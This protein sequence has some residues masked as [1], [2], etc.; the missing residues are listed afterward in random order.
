MFSFIEIRGG[1]RF[2][3]IMEYQS[4]YYVGD[5][6]LSFDERDV[7][8]FNRTSPFDEDSDNDGMCDGWEAWFGDRVLDPTTEEPRWEVLDPTFGGDDYQDPDKDTIETRWNFVHWLWLDEDGD[9]VHEPPRGATPYDPVT[10]G[11]NIHEYLV[12]TNPRKADTDD[13]SYP[14]GGNGMNDFDENVFHLTDP[15]RAYTDGD[16]VA[17]GFEVWYNM[18]PMDTFDGGADPDADGLTNVQEF[19]HDTHPFSSDTDEDLMPDGWEIQ[20]SLDPHD[21]MDAMRDEDKEGLLNCFEYFNGTNPWIIDTDGDYLTD[22]EEARGNWTVVVDGA[23]RL[24]S[25]DPLKVDSDGDD[26]IDDEDG[27][28]NNDPLEEILDGF[29][30]D[31]DAEIL[32]NNGIDDDGDGVIDDGRTGIPAVGLP[33]G[34]DEEHDFNDY[35]EVFVYK[36]NASNPDSDGDGLDDW[37]EWFTDRDTSTSSIERTQPLL[38]DTDSDG[39]DDLTEVMGIR[40]WLPDHTNKVRRRTDPLSHDSDSDGLSDGDEVL[41][42][43]ILKTPWTVNSTDP[44]NEDT[45]GDGMSDHYEVMYSD[46]DGD[47]LPTW[48]EDLYAGVW[49]N[50]GVKRDANLE[51]HLDITEDW[52]SD[53]LSNLEEFM[54]RTDPWEEDTD[55]DG[56]GD[57]LD[58]SLTPDHLRPV[59]RVPLFSD[60]DGDIMPDWWEVINGLDPEDPG[61]GGKDPDHDMLVNRDEY[62]YD[63]DPFNY[64]TDGDGSSDLF[65][66][67]LMSSPDAWDT[68]HDGMADWW[69]RLYPEILDHTDPSDADSND[70]GD[71]WTNYQE[72]VYASDPYNHVPTN[73][74]LTST[75]GDQYMD[76]EDPYP[77]LINT[78]LRPLNPTRGSGPIHPL[79]VLTPNGEYQ[80]SADMDRDGLNNSGESSVP[81]GATDPTDPDT[82]GDG[83]PDGWEVENAAWDP[84]TAQPNL[85]PLK[86]D[87]AFLDPDWDGVSYTLDRDDNGDWIIRQMDI[88]GDG[89]FDP[90]FENETLCNLEEY[91]FGEDLDR[92]GINERTPDPNMLDT[93]DDEIPDGWEILLNDADGDN[94]STWFE[95]TYA[96]DPLSPRGDDGADGD[97]D[98]DG[99]SNLDEFLY[100]TNPIDPDD[101]P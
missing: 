74:T 19:K 31:G 66:H 68:D 98:G 63:L 97:P 84:L 23:T 51:G 30:N 58:L 41:V 8:M 26:L 93:D 52:D 45:D 89:F 86:G 75:D 39:L 16:G 99:F 60:R 28:G 4:M 47:G 1:E 81:T 10:V 88:N 95:L 83:M 57:L 61:D 56:I 55:G 91:L 65:D 82:D 12:G 6:S 21:P 69:E 80:A 76:D 100:N 90:T 40:I 77:L 15:L 50:V 71:R 38:S 48:W 92:D 5:P 7:M 78:T 11:F 18:D 20:Q 53:G 35:N 37:L 62:I 94:L 59:K 3:N 2:T 72:W 22:F 49:S 32:Q 36:T 33:E 64:N 79:T 96:L 25:S 85:D 13:D 27:D 101:H 9:G 44:L 17:D 24:Y 43:Y 87:D 70:D 14:Q 46:L 54:Y 34:V 42:D 73:P 67:E 29:D